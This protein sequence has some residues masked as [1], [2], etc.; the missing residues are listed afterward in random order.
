M[1]ETLSDS[2]ILALSQI[3][4]R[5]NQQ[6]S[7]EAII[8]VVPCPHCKADIDQW[9]MGQYGKRGQLPHADRRCAAEIWRKKNPTEWKQLRDDLVI[10]FV[11]KS[12]EKGGDS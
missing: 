10:L 7:N 8:A 4:I 11:K 5:A 12:L 1:V 6:S 9:C 2:T 3:C